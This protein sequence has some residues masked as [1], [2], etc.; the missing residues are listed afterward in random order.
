MQ[1]YCLLVQ[2]DTGDKKIYMAKFDYI[3]G[4][5]LPPSVMSTKIE[6]EED[7]DLLTTNRGL[8]VQFSITDTVRLLEGLQEEAEASSLTN[9]D[10]VFAFLA[11]DEALLTMRIVFCGFKDSEFKCEIF[12]SK[13]LTFD[14]KK[15]PV[16]YGKVSSIQVIG[17]KI[18]VVLP[19]RIYQFG[20]TNVKQ[21][22]TNYGYSRSMKQVQYFSG[23]WF[24]ISK[25]NVLFTLEPDPNLGGYLVETTF[26]RTEKKHSYSKLVATESYILA[27]Y[28]DEDG[29]AG[30]SIYYYSDDNFF[31]Q[32]EKAQSESPSPPKGRIKPG[33]L[34][35]RTQSG[36]SQFPSASTSSITSL[37]FEYQFADQIDYYY[38]WNG[39]LLLFGIPGALMM[40]L[41]PSIEPPAGKIL[42]YQTVGTLNQSYVFAGSDLIHLLPI[43]SDTNQ[44]ACITARSLRAGEQ[45]KE[46]SQGEGREKAH[47]FINS[48]ES[49]RPVLSFEKLSPSE[50]QA[51]KSVKI[52]LYFKQQ[53]NR[54]IRRS[55]TI[56]F[57]YYKPGKW[58]LLWIALACVVLLFLAILVLCVVKSVKAM[59]KRENY[60]VTDNEASPDSDYSSDQFVSERI[61]NRWR[62]TNVKVNLA[63]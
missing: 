31:K 1:N 47:L 11:I 24:G 52:E 48:I 32:S 45:K 18:L 61:P 57:E 16:A 10:N 51:L 55:Y 28:S 17:D 6:K 49:A 30:F 20:L 5:Y 9:L 29:S 50:L 54:Y 8:F 26:F 39:N 44:C 4:A 58:M 25:A 13:Y 36:Q 37:D 60:S 23:R 34:S 62:S 35:S 15:P 19:N 27:K 3:K 14:G 41:P 40:S 46:S 42:K 59:R 2:F 7:Q 56:R 33:N 38:E 63:D 22:Q 21:N 12:F 43:N 53:K